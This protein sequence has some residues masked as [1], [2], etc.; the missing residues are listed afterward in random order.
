VKPDFILHLK[1]N[2]PLAV[3]VVGL[4]VYIPIV[5][6][7]GVFFTN[8]GRIIRSND[9]TSYWRWIARLL[10]LFLICLVVLLGSYLLSRH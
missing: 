4:F 8:Q 6:V 3:I 7:S 9:P 5:L 2:W 1:H 10:G